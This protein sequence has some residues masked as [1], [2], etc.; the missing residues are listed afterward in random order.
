MATAVQAGTGKL[1]RKLTYLDLTMMSLGGI[2]GSGWLYGSMRG[3]AIAGPS[4]VISWLIG[5]VAVLLIGL[6]YAE[7]GGAMPEAGALVRY[8]QYTHG[9]FVSFLM[10]WAMLVAYASVPPIE[11]EA[12]V[13]F[14]NYY[15]P[16]LYVG[17]T[18]TALGLFI[19]FLLMVVFFLLNY[20]SVNV[21]GKTNTIW[22][23]I[24]FVIPAVT[25]I[26]LLVTSS[27]F[28]NFTQYGGFAPNGSS[29][30]MAAVPLGGMIFAYLGFRQAL[31]MGGEAIN[32][33]R[34][35]PRAVITS[36]VIGI[37][38]YVLLQTSFIAAMPA[39]VLGKGW[40]GI[41][42][43]SPFANLVATVG[44]GWWAAILFADAIWSPAG[45]GNVYTASTTRIMLAMT[46]NGYFP[47]AFAWINPKSG[48]PVWALLCTVILGLVFLLPFPAWA[49]L[50]G[51]VSSATVFTYIV[52]PI[53]IAVLRKTAPDLK[54]PFL[55]KGMSVIAP[56]G[57]V[58]ASLIIYWSGWATDSV[59]LLAIL[60]GVILYAYGTS[61]FAADTSQFAGQHLKAGIWL[62]VY[63]LVMLLMTYIGS[64]NFG[65][66]HPV[67][68]Y[69]LDL[70]VVAVL[71][72]IFYYWGV[73]SGWKT[74]DID[75][76]LAG[77]ELDS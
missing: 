37:V 35:V 19:A 2:I 17:A 62:V 49:A 71:A 51:V 55:L 39:S 42:F 45:T 23:L 40:S 70:V 72:L 65:A 67:I 11:A 61:S 27:H 69:P 22:T 43:S 8:P 76:V 46:R 74:A 5:G 16:G 1:Q 33:Q 59:V 44:F 30:I 25:V 9:S 15:L 4:A 10:G 68:A 36:I 60:F 20:W 54:R 12:A 6:V 34:D 47:K 28:G 57:F 18:L 77:K 63:I 75:Q 24:K 48:I 38:L 52:G 73:N 31:D 29:A 56:L 26:L 7:L 58:V 64:A 13:Q 41:N 53:S 32:P 14:A 66:P 3:A 50:V 21:F